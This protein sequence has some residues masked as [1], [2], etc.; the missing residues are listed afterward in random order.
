MAVFDDYAAY[1]G[2]GLARLVRTGA[3]SPR[4]LLDSAIARIEALNPRVNAVVHRLYEDAER[5]IAAGLPDGPFTGV[6]YLLKDLYTFYEGAPVGNGSRLFADFVAPFNDP[7]TERARAAGLVIL[8][9]TNTS[10]FGISVSTEPAVHGPTRNPWDLGRS[11]GGSSGGSAAAVAAGM[12]PMADA[13][14]GGGSIRIPASACGLFGLKP[15]RGRTPGSGGWSGLAVRHAVTR[16]VRDAAALLDVFSGPVAGDHYVAPPPARPFLAEAGADPRRL[17]IATSLAVAEGIAVHE[18]CRAGL[19]AA[20]RLCEGLGHHVEEAA[21][22]VDHQGL[23]AA[24]LTIVEA[25]VADLLTAPHPLRG[26]AIHEHEVEATTWLM[27]ERGRRHAA[28]DLARAQ[29]FV[30]LLGQTLGRFFERYDVLLTPTLAE[31]PWPLGAIDAQSDD[32]DAFYRRIRAAIPFTQMFNMGGQPAASIPLYWTGDGLPIG[33]QA[34][35]AFGRE[36]LLIRLASQLE[37]AQPWAARRA[38]L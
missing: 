11:P 33:V 32:L 4:E 12:V 25:H 27:G 20:A 8:G 38:P 36:D 10:E 14:D 1:D 31:P 7:M 30:R 6:P 2:V 16:S 19:A 17:R 23:Q 29:M 18:D 24:M 15:S 21:P 13:S 5:T 28:V 3:V 34:A 22:E 37:A 26:G 35:A 9:K